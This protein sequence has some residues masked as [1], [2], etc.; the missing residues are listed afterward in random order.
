M[1]T[2]TLLMP[3]LLGQ[4][5]GA[6]AKSTAGF[7]WELITTFWSAH[8]LLIS[9]ILVGWLV[10]EIATRNGGAHYNSRNGFSP[11][12]NKFVGSGTYL[13]LQAIVYAC[14]RFFFG[15]TVYT[16]LWP[17]G[18]HLLAFISAGLLLNLT[19]F[20]VYWKLPKF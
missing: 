9:L 18:L 3:E 2:T 14:L 6:T 11:S 7:F 12:F 1:A 20:W 19:G 10:F 16:H 4:I 15:D 8:W 5:V 17:Y 13:L